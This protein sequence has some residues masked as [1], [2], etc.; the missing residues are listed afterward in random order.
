V[1]AFNK[2]LESGLTKVCCE[3]R[4][5]IIEFQQS[6]G[7]IGLPTKKLHKYTPFQLVYNKEVVV[8]AMF[9]TPSLYIAQATHMIDDESIAQTIAD[10]LELEEEIFLADFH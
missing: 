9:I 10:L 4:D 2:I 5:G 8:P 7:I 6:Y 1:E 3:N